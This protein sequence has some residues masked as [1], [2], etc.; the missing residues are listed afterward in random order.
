MDICINN[1]ICIK[2]I[3][4]LICSL[5]HLFVTIRIYLIATISFRLAL[6]IRN[7]VD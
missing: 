4:E 5:Q 6:D 2:V 1:V 3:K 7:T